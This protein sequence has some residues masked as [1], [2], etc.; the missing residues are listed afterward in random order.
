MS[1]RRRPASSGLRNRR[2]Q[3]KVSAT[4]ICSNKSI[5]KESNPLVYF[6]ILHFMYRLLAVLGGPLD[7][8]N[9]GIFIFIG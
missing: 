1:P 8:L 5:K 4:K 6:V 3:I 9:L 2:L 7:P